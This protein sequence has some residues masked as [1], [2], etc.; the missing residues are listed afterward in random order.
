[1]VASRVALSPTGVCTAKA[2]T[3]PSAESA[4]PARTTGRDTAIT[5]SGTAAP[6]T[7]R[8]PDRHRPAIA[9]ATPASPRNRPATGLV[10]AASSAQAVVP[11][12]RGHRRSAVNA[13]RASSPSATPSAKVTRPDTRLPM[14]HTAPST[15][16]SSGRR[17]PV[18]TNRAASATAETAAA[19]A[20]VSRAPSTAITAGATTLYPYWT[21]PPYQRRSTGLRPYS[22][23]KSARATCADRSV[24]SGGASRNAIA[25][26]AATR[27]AAATGLC[28]IE[29]PL[30]RLPGPPR[31]T[32][33]VV[34]VLARI[35]AG[36][37][38][39]HPGHGREVRS[40]AREL[41]RGAA[42][43]ER[44]R[45]AGARCRDPP[46]RQ[47]RGVRLADQVGVRG[48]TKGVER[49]RSAQPR[50]RMPMPQLEQLHGPLDIGQPAAT[51]LRVRRRIRAAGQAFVVHPG[52]DPADL[53]DLRTVQAARRVTE[54]VGHGQEPLAQR[55]VTADEAGAQQRLRLP[56]LRP[57]RV[58]VLVRAQA[59]HQRTLPPLRAQIG[60][61][62]Q[63]RL[64]RG[65]REQPPQLL[66]YGVRRTA[67]RVFGHAARRLVDEQHVGV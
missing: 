1:M 51:Q 52:L 25:S 11:A 56:D 37:A 38:A 2:A 42:A 32:Q 21:V 63:S 6:P 18:R 60:V 36:R 58:V 14:K 12:M 9:S 50:D 40:V 46:R 34:E 24:P 45:V 44:Q 8:M 62:A 49:T 59:A 15:P 26:A 5:T 16:P 29:N 33:I 47:R 10:A 43:H 54:A 41:V 19:S 17:A 13:S 23:T 53:V 61:D 27:P 65:P 30:D 22:R 28:R 55:G 31:R 67:G 3:T 20:P 35:R 48:G 39:Q 57:A 4:A 7:S 66:G 64:R